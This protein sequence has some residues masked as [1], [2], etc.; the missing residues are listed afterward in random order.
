[1]LGP[2]PVP[3]RASEQLDFEPQLA[4]L[5]A[6]TRGVA[7]A[8]REIQPSVADVPVVTMQNGVRSD[9]LVADVLGTD[10]LLSCVI[11]IG[12][13]SLEP[14]KVTY[15]PRGALV[16]GVPFGPKSRPK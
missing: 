7:G 6:K 15:A 14:G 16:L 9:E 1:V 11:L 5:T 13:S 2:L 4:L 10:N 3:V 12:A 8:A